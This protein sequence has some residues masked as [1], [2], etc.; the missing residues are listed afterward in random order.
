[1]QLHHARPT[2]AVAAN[3]IVGGGRHPLLE[4]SF[5]G[6]A[7]LPVTPLLQKPSEQHRK[8]TISKASNKK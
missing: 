5:S 6:Q 4:S 2:W 7:E 3:A 8:I 1:M